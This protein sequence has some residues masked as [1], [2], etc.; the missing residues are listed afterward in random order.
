[1]GLI[2][3]VAIIGLWLIHLIYILTLLSADYTLIKFYL[4]VIVQA[5]LY[6]GLFITGHDAMHGTVTK[7][8]IINRIVGTVAIFLYAG[9]S[10]NKLRKNHFKHHKYPGTGFDP[11]FN[12]GSQNFIFWWGKFM[13]R[14][15]TFMQILVMALAYNILKIWVG[16][17]NLWLF[18][19]LPAF[20]SSLQLFFFGTYL[21]HKQPH[22]HEMDPHKS[23]TQKKNHIFAM[24]SCYFFGYHFEHHNSPHTPWWKLYRLK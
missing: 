16:E 2:I 6:T 8:K 15:A 18:W 10:Y 14:Y 11:D 17:I 20:L 4:H 24:L 19:I 7:H 13:I 22:T 5:Y 12:V 23:R 3:A 21:P 9:L 1:M